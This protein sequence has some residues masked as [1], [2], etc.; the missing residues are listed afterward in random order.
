MA[1]GQSL[2]ITPM[3]IA[4]VYAMVANDGVSVEPRLLAKWSDDEGK[5]HR[6]AAPRGRR[7]LPADVAKTLRS[8]LRSVVTEGTGTL[9]AVP[10]YEVAGKTGTARRA[11]EGV[12]YSG[13]YASFVGMLPAKS[14]RVV[15]AVALDNPVPYEGGLAA[16]PVFAQVATDAVRI[17]RITPD[18]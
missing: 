18:R 11:V 7:V 1:I 15:I 5:I 8:M 2:T 6:P 13:H 17:L 3:Q 4:Q 12:G 16:A 10:H 9:A 14:P